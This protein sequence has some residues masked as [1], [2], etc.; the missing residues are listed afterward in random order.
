MAFCIQCGNPLAADARFC[1]NCGTRVEPIAQA[2]PASVPEE[3]ELQPVCT[4]VAVEEPVF[5]PEEPAFTPEEPVFTPQEPVFTPEPQSEPVYTPPVQEAP[6]PVWQD[7]PV[8]AGPIYADPPEPAYVPPV[9]AQRKPLIA[10]K[11]LSLGKKILVVFL[12]ILAFIFGTATVMALCL[13]FTLTADNVAAFLENVDVSEMEAT[14]IITDAKKDSTLADWLIEQLESRG[15]DC[16][17]LNNNDVEEFLNKCILPFVQ[18]EAYE[19]A[20]ALLTGKGKAAV[21]LDEIRELVNDSRYYLYDEHGV[22]ISDE[23]AEVLVD[24]IDSFGVTE[25]ANT[26]YLEKEYGDILDTARLVLSWAAVAVF[27][28][29]TFLILLFIWLTNKSLIRNLNTTGTIATVIGGMFAVFTVINLILPDLLLTIC[30]NIDILHAAVSMVITSGTTVI[31]STLGVG[32]F[33][34]LL[35]RLL[36]IKVRK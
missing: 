34:L 23:H 16:S 32:V 12:S 13:R 28:F 22:I 26:R 3:A 4:P 31:L 15:I 35:S 18:D 36:Q 11:P 19:F 30:G 25:M 10:K 33:L 6:K 17:A 14:T 21:T 20:S 1:A 2:V 24:W 8:E 27:G 5:T 7:A 29:L 9:K